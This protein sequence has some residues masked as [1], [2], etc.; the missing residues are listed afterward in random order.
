MVSYQTFKASRKTPPK[1]KKKP[2]ISILT[3]W[4]TQ[5]LN[6]QHPQ[7]SITE[8]ENRTTLMLMYLGTK[9]NN[10]SQSIYQKNIAKRL[11]KS[12]L[13]NISQVFL[14]IFLKI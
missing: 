1:N 11:D 9:K 8:S 10:H 13:P 3:S 4:I 5:K 14:H 6:F 2:I 12:A 7:N